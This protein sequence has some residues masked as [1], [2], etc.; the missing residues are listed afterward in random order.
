MV[1]PRGTLSGWALSFHALRKRVFWHLL[2]GPAVRGAACFHATAE[3]EYQDI[4]NLGFVQPVCI[5]PNG[6]DVPPMCKPHGS[7]RRRLLFLGRIHPKKGLTGLLRAWK[8]IQDRYRD[9]ELHVVGPDNDNHLADVRAQAV[10]MRLERLVMPGPLYG[11]DKLNAYRTAD[12]FVLPTHS[13]NFGM[14]VAEALAAGTPAV[15][16]VA[17]P[18]SR[19]PQ[20]GAGWSIELGVDPLVS[21][22][23]EAL[24]LSPERLAEMGLVGHRWMEK[25]FAWPKIGEQCALTYRWLLDGGEV[26]PWVRMN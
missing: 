11:W 13:E 17:A 16:T 12:L 24:G 5:L 14:T 2:Q 1:S 23:E 25:E 8:A 19:L 26:P 10:A 3:S 15:V 7:G 22:L 6:V 21:C 18:W 20:E 4:R 9:W